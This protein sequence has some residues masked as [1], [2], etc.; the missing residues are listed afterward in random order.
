ML[1]GFAILASLLGGLARGPWWFWLIGGGALAILAV[2]DPRRLRP[3]YADVGT[4]DAL[5]LLLNDLRVVSSG[6]LA[7]ATAFAAGSALS[8]VLPL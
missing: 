1:A 2:T 6:C 5:P 7:S 8:W 3:S 4:L